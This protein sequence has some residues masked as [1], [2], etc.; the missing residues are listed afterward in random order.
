MT[1][2]E[3]AESSREEMRDGRA[4]YDARYRLEVFESVLLSGTTPP[5]ERIVQ[6]V[7][8]YT[9]SLDQ[10]EADAVTIERLRA[11]VER[12]RNPNTLSL[13]LQEVAKRGEAAGNLIR[14]LYWRKSK[15]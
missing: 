5:H 12:L 9:R 15:P 8:E 7:K 4:L 13:D 1:T 14:E 11:E 2:A 3:I 6:I 10:I